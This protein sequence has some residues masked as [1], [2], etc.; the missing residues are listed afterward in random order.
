MI[1]HH[2]ESNLNDLDVIMENDNDTVN[3]MK[4]N[5]VSNGSED[6]LKLSEFCESPIK[7]IK[8]FFVVLF[9]I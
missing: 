6:E 4:S 8:E 2:T 7:K 1:F 9:M 3:T 5:N